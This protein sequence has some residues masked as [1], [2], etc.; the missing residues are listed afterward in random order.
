MTHHHKR[1]GGREIPD[2]DETK[3][4]IMLA[5]KEILMAAGGALRF[6][7]NYVE[8]F[9]PS[10]PRPHLITFFQKAIQV[11]DELGNGIA[12][13]SCLKEKAK[14]AI[15]PFIDVVENEMKLER[16]FEKKQKRTKSK[17]YKKKR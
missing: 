1:R 5:G 11:A 13:V 9:S 2:M 16:A 17:K 4:H 12:Q 3:E 7:K 8:S 14:G 15:Q 6:C 10:E